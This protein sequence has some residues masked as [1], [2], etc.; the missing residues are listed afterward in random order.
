MCDCE[1]LSLCY[2]FT[3][4]SLHPLRTFTLLA[5]RHSEK[6]EEGT[7][8]LDMYEDLLGNLHTTPLWGV[9]EGGGGGR[10]IIGACVYRAQLAVRYAHSTLGE[11][12]IHHHYCTKIT[13]Y[14][15]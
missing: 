15:S 2:E 1:C 4:S 5:S 14:F 6:W 11:V 3:C 13:T 10:L 12:W 8:C 7:H 9:E